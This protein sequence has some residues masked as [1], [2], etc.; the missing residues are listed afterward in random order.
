VSRTQRSRL[1]SRSSRLSS[2]CPIQK[3]PHWVK[4]IPGTFLGYARGS[5]GSS[6]IARQRK[7]AGYVSQRI[8]T[9][10]DFAEADNDV[11][12]DYW[13]AFEKAKRVQVEARVPQPRH[14]GDG[15]TINRIVDEYITE[16]TTTPGGRNNDVMSESS[17]KNTRQLWTRHAG[18]LGDSLATAVTAEQIK[19][20]HAGIAKSAPTKRGKALSFDPQDPAQVS[21]R[22]QSANR[23]LTILK[24]ALQNARDANKLPAD[25][26]DYWRRVKPFKTKDDELPRMLEKAEITRLLNAAASDLRD[27]LT[28][29]LMTGARYGEVTGLR[30]GDYVSETGVVRLKQ[31]KTGKVLWQPL[32]PEG[33]RFFERVCAGRGEAE[34]MFLQF[35]GR[36]W[37]KS[38]AARP[39]KAAAEAAKVADVSFKATRATYGKLLLLATKD[40]ELVAKALGHSDSRITRRHY[41]A[42]L[43]SEVQKGVAKL[44]SLG[45][46]TGGKVRKIR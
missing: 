8:G 19:A 46:E 28:A 26:P 11:V 32:T 36:P 7:G 16:R 18:R 35:D 34:T 13:Q 14:Y 45:I 38:A 1:E 37:A 15:L 2:K 31:T 39:M 41:A 23:I 43:P 22:R 10:D 4:V 33:V 12:L 24:A 40:L 6:W 5:T 9:P 25:L 30:V 17:A 20:W 27:L 21:A 3:E 42:L 29:A 44:P